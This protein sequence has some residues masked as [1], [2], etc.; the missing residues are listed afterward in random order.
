MIRVRIWRGRA[1]ACSPRRPREQAR[2]ILATVV[3]EGTGENAARRGLHRRRQDR[4]CAEGAAETVAG[5]AK[6]KYVASFAGFLPAED[7]Q[8]LIIVSIDE[9]SNAIYGGAVAAPTFSRLAEFSVSHLRIP[10]S[11]V[12]EVSVDGSSTAGDE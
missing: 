6:D 5:Y 12:R 2:E 3:I 10:P 4:H 8:V 1:S 7:P 9:P 11:T